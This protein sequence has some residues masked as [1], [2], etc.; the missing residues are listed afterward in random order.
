MVSINSNEWLYEGTALNYVCVHTY[1]YIHLTEEEIRLPFSVS[2][3]YF[4]W[5]IIYTFTSAA[6]NI[7][8][9]AFAISG[10]IPSPSINVN[11]F[12]CF[13]IFKIF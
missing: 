11:F 12:T 3:E 5:Y 2:V 13:G 10:P 4:R 6:L 7:F 9:T 1:M 8:L